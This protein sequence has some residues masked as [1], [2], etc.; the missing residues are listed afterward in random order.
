MTQ[1]SIQSMTTPSRSK[2]RLKFAPKAEVKAAIA[3]YA[4]PPPPPPPPPLAPPAAP[5][6][7]AKPT[8]RRLSPDAWYELVIARLEALRQA[9]PAAFRPCDD[10]GPWPPL[11][12]SIHKSIR[13]RDPVLGRPYALLQASLA[14]YTNDHRYRAGRI[15]GAV[16]IDLDGAPVSMCNG[17]PPLRRKR[18]EAMKE[19]DAKEEEDAAPS[20]QAA[21]S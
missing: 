7:A 17:A 16:R 14:R 11:A 2:L 12:V 8:A 19:S 6:A 9:W 18:R 20:T 4:P 15:E 3:T 10:P 5:K 21:P 1:S 13:Q